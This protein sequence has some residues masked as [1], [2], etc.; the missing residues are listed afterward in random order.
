MVVQFEPAARR[1]KSFCLSLYWVA[2]TDHWWPMPKVSKWP[3]SPTSAEVLW[4]SICNWPIAVV[5]SPA[6]LFTVAVSA[7]L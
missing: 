4:I 6:L 1:P 7:P 3:R 5:K 2:L